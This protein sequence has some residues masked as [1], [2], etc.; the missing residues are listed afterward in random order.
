M[1]DRA[2]SLPCNNEITCDLTCGFHEPKYVITFTHKSACCCS[3]GSSSSVVAAAAWWRGVGSYLWCLQWTGRNV[4]QGKKPK[5][6][7]QQ[8]L[9]SRSHGRMIKS[10]NM[11]CKCNSRIIIGDTYW[12]YSLSWYNLVRER[13][14]DGEIKEKKTAQKRRIIHILQGTFCRHVSAFRAH[15]PGT[16]WR[17]WIVSFL[18]VVN[19]FQHLE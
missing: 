4:T 5:T 10:Q 1:S 8:S 3:S 17:G 18:P 6:K 11:F 19:V 2:T 7:R 13:E 15:H 12:D 9:S 16:A 14:W